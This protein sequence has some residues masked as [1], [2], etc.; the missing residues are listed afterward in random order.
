MESQRC[1]FL[2]LWLIFKYIP[3]SLGPLYLLCCLKGLEMLVT[4]FLIGFN[5]SGVPLL[6]ER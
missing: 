4:S 1:E 5:D 3:G 2:K 6:S